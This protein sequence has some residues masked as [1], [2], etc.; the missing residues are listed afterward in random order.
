MANRLTYVQEEMIGKLKGYGVNHSFVAFGTGVVIIGPG[1]PFNV[2][3]TDYLASDLDKLAEADF[4]ERKKLQ[5]GLELD[6][7][8]L[9]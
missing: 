8:V 4:L 7:Y 5:D 9:K 1:E 6:T 3:S 2:Y